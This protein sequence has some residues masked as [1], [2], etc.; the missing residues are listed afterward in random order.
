LSVIE[1]I[2]VSKGRLLFNGTSIDFGPLRVYKV[3]EAFRWG[4][5]VVC[6]GYTSAS[7]DIVKHPE[8]YEGFQPSELIYFKPTERV[9]RTK[10]FGAGS[11]LSLEIVGE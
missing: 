4:A 5:W 8:K 7:E 10:P 1:K 2:R 3:R 9:G 11:P 6:D